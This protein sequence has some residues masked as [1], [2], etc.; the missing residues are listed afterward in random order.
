MGASP[1]NT[2]SLVT[3]VM[4]GASRLP[5]GEAFREETLEGSQ[6]AQWPRNGLAVNMPPRQA[7]SFMRPPRPHAP[8][9]R[10]LVL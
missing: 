8:V 7:A 3:A 5:A 1:L 6:A 9:S 2:T 10:K 4:Y